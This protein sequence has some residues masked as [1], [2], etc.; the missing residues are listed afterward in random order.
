MQQSALGQPRVFE[1]RLDDA[2]VRVL[3]DPRHEPRTAAAGDGHLLAHRQALQA[4]G[5]AALGGPP[6]GRP[7]SRLGAQPHQIAPVEGGDELHGAR[8][9]RLGVAGQLAP[10]LVGTGELPGF[11]QQLDHL[12]VEKRMAQ[13]LAQQRPIELCQVGTD[14]RRQ[15][16][17]PG[18]GKLLRQLLVLS[19]CV[20]AGSAVGLPGPRIEI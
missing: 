20:P 17:L 5:Q 12:G 10:H 1:Q 16:A 2:R 11:Q 9:R 7:D 19:P 4:V 14:K 15:L 18:G 13:K 8:V 3:T 6:H